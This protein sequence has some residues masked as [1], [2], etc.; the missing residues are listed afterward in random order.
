VADQRSQGVTSGVTRCDDCGLPEP[1][2]P[3]SVATF[4]L[5]EKQWAVLHQWARA[6]RYYRA[7]MGGAF[8]VDDEVAFVH[9]IREEQRL[10]RQVR[11]D[12]RDNMSVGAVRR[13]LHLATASG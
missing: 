7:E 6:S 13:H 12:Q 9:W 2:D 1:L 5:T 10:R 3:E 8:D 11:G 4:A